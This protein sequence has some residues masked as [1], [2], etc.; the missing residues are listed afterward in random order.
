MIKAISRQILEV[1]DTGNTYFEKAW[2][3]ISPEFMNSGADRLENEAE[4][5]LRGLDA[6]SSIKN[7]H[8]FALRF[9]SLIASAAAGGLIT[10]VFF[11]LY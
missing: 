9:F 10:A 6:P 2:L 8:R 5:Y 4:G 1:S 11:Q 7:N 3:M